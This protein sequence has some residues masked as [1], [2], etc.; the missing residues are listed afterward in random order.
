MK[1]LFLL[2]LFIGA[3]SIH[4]QTT[5]Y[6]SA[7]TDTWVAGNPANEAVSLVNEIICFLK[8]ATG[9]NVTDFLGK[10]FKS[11]V[12]MDECEQSSGGGALD[13]SR[14]KGKSSENA[15][16]GDSSNNNIAVEDKD[17]MIVIND[18][19]SR[20]SDS[21]PIVSKAWVYM[22]DTDGGGGFDSFDRDIY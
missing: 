21:D 8:N 1:K 20:A 19:A 22:P 16:Q 13:E 12:Y 5:D 2:S 17:S 10:K 9:P 3:V 14:G 7:T 11:V 15:A 18:V 6:D 4:A